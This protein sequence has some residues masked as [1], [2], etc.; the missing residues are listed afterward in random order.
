MSVHDLGFVSD[1][2]GPSPILRPWRSSSASDSEPKSAAISQV[3]DSTRG[4]ELRHTYRQ[5][6]DRNRH[7]AGA[8]HI[9]ERNGVRLA[10]IDLP[11]PVP[12]SANTTYVASYHTDMGRY[13]FN[14]RIPGVS[15][16]TSPLFA[17]Q[18]GLDGPN[19][20]YLYGPTAFPTELIQLE[21]LL[22]RR[23]VR[24]VRYRATRHRRRFPPSRRLPGPTGSQT[25]RGQPTRRPVLAV[26]YGVSPGA[27]G[28]SVDNA[29]LVTSHSMRLTGLVPNTTY[30]FRV[31]STDVAGNSATAPAPPSAP[32]TFTRVRHNTVLIDTTVADFSAGSPSGASVVQA[33]DGEV[34]LTPT[35]GAEFT[36]TSLPP[37]WS[38]IPWDTGGSSAVG[39]GRLTTDGA[40]VSADVAYPAGRSLEFVATFQ[41]SAWQHVGFGVTFDE[42]P[43]IMFS[44]YTGGALYARTNDG[45]QTTDTP[46]PGNWLG[47]PHRYRIDWT[48]TN[49]IYSIDGAEVANHAMAIPTAL[50]P[51]VSDFTVGGDTLSVD[52]IR[53]SPYT[54]SGTFLSRVLD[55]GGPTT[56]GTASWTGITRVGTS[57]DLQVRTGDTPV[58][59]ATWSTFVAIPLPGTPLGM[60]GRYLQYQAQ[61]H[62]SVPAD[63][64]IL[65]DVSFGMSG[66]D[67]SPPLRSNGQPSGTLP[68]G[69]TQATLSLTTNEAATCRYAT[70]PGVSFAAMPNTFGTTNGTAHSTVVTGLTDGESYTHYVRCADETNNANT[71][72]FAITFTV[73]SAPQPSISIADLS[74]NE[75]N[76]GTTNA[77]VTLSMSAASTTAVT[78]SFLTA[79]GSATAGS[80]YT[81][82]SSTATFAANSTSTTISIPVIGDT[83][84]EPNES[85]VVN[86]SSPVGATIADSQATVTILND[87]QPSISIADLSLNEGNAATTNAVVTLSLSAPKATAVTVNFATANGSATAGSDYTTASGTATFAANATSTTISI[88]VTG[89]TTAEL[90][91]SFVVNLSSPVGATIADSQ[92]TVT[93]V[94]DDQ[95][96]LTIGNR[97]VTEGDTGTVTAA[98]TVTL[99]P[100]SA[101]PVTVSYATANGSALAG[102]D[103][104]ATSG[105]LTFTPGATSRTINVPVLGDT[106]DEANETFTVLLS[107][108]TNATL[109][110][111]SQGT[112]TI[113][114]ND[115]A[116]SLG[117]NDVTV[118]EE[119]GPVTTTFTVTLSAVS[120][121]TV[122][123]NYATSNG[124]ATTAAGDYVGKS[125]SLSFLPGTTTQSVSVTVNGDALNENNETFNLNLSGASAATIADSRGVATIVDDD[126]T[127]TL[128]I[129]DVSI[130]E[131]NSGTKNATFTVSLS[132]ASGRTVTVAYATANGS[133]VAVLDYSSRSG[134]LTFNPESC[135]ERL[136]SR[137]SVTGHRKVTRRSSS[138]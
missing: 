70:T 14:R 93:I 50:R 82:A 40:R 115:A 96:L 38:S 27:L 88:P 124:T 64:P 68:I 105:Q 23:G 6:L 13:S 87:D 39:S 19:G 89:D 107:A 99:S 60:T 49:V 129:L 57:I 104:T 117:V 41:P 17:L 74:L 25:S 111:A 8:G 79:N 101:G 45:T 76:A 30:Y 44:T 135:R 20:V 24:D 136:R 32:A 59:D 54:A 43:W 71:D 118:T 62:S 125:G 3:C 98:F 110:T 113:T 42:T 100:A 122:T 97:T 11:T 56:W 133:A 9:H 63:T 112:G 114:D 55:A 91:E 121:R 119:N 120:G 134:T 36:G 34:I 130:T 109:G 84:V 16:D 4:C 86:L 92:A 123:V 83:T 2:R 5:S 80:D 21:Q 106:L 95:P 94:N 81:A 108:P 28:Q 26:D 126:P 31:R 46:L 127:P 35:A 15:T 53:M 78:V 103:Y 75:G 90:N 66:T 10:G 67:S 138:I 77:V 128:A 73:G 72:D 58:P 131:G 48:A 47:S 69:T 1:A 85:F 22:G 12:I 61:L 137:L 132:T 102:S 65:Q 33:A 116:P 29:T 18:D 51:I 52:W 7:A 37:G